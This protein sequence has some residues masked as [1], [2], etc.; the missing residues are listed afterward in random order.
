M[1]QLLAYADSLTRGIVPTTSSKVDGVPA[2]ADRYA[3]LGTTLAA[4]VAPLRNAAD[5]WVRPDV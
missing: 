5:G 3:T 2:S 1:Q 4:M